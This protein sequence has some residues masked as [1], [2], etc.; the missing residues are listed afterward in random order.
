MPWWAS[1]LVESGHLRGSGVFKF[2]EMFR[3]FPCPSF[4][5]EEIYIYIIIE[6]EREKTEINVMFIY[7]NKQGGLCQL[8]ISCPQQTADS[9]RHDRSSNAR[10]FEESCCLRSLYLDV[11]GRKLG[12]NG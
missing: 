1:V 6:R 5:H 11:P 8:L 9:C 7:R 3:S 10:N 4:S 2:S 12:S